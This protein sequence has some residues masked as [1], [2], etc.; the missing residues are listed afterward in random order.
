MPKLSD[1][2][3]DGDSVSQPASKNIDKRASR[4]AEN[5]NTRRSLKWSGFSRKNGAIGFERLTNSQLP[6]M[7]QKTHGISVV[8]EKIHGWKIPKNLLADLNNGLCDMRIHLSISLYHMKSLTFFGTAWNG[9]SVPL[10]D[11]K[12]QETLDVEYSD[13]IYIL[14][15]LI[16]TSCI[17]IV[18]VVASKIEKESNVTTAQYG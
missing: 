8:F 11:S 1:D 6:E 4:N 2:E 7:S 18:E 16:D 3:N 10:P 5:E 17:G 9:A 15:R 12:L 14:T 13:I